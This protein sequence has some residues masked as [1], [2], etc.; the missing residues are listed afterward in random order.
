MDSIK[1][2][3]YRKVDIELGIPIFLELHLQLEYPHYEQLNSE[4]DISFMRELQ[5]AINQMIDNG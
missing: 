2:E 1:N 5:V 3:L 4:L